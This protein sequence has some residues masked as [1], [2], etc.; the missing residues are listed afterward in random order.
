MNED[1]YL[2]PLTVEDSAISWRWRNDPSIWR[3]TGSRPDR[4]VTEEMERE[5]AAKV[6]ADSSRM[7]FAICC[8]VDNQYIGN[9]YIVN[10]HE[11]VGELGI[12]IGEL[13]ARGR[14]YG[15]Q[16]LRLL[17]QEAKSRGIDK[18]VIDVAKDNIAAIIV[19]LKSGARFIKGSDGA[20]MQM[21]IRV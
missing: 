19:Y 3:Y 9:V 17:K 10:I 2:R 5:W 18:I 20:R 12:F 4:E 15:L 11:E 14:G 16:A 8:K 7:N 13:S 6:I 1:I 21:L